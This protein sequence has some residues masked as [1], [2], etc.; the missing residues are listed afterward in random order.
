MDHFAEKSDISFCDYW[1]SY[2]LQNEH[3][4]NSCIVIRNSKA[5]EIIHEMIQKRM[6]AIEKELS[7]EEVLDTQKIVLKAKKS[8][9]RTTLKHKVF[10]KICDFVFKLRIY[11]L[12]G[13]HS[14]S[15]FCKFYAY[16]CR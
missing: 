15:L 9:L 1:N 6:I 11:R 3:V 4:G 8:N 14:Y 13:Y 10:Y 12:M 7:E 16:I 2:E 5:D